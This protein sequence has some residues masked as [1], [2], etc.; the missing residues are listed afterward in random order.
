MTSVFWRRGAK[1]Q[2]WV[3]QTLE[4]AAVNWGISLPHLPAEV[5]ETTPTNSGQRMGYIRRHLPQ[6]SPIRMGSSWAPKLRR[7]DRPL[8]VLDQAFSSTNNS[9]SYLYA[10]MYTHKYAHTHT[11]G[12]LMIFSPVIRVFLCSWLIR[13]SGD[14][15]FTSFSLFTLL[16]TQRYWSCPSLRDSAGWWITLYSFVNNIYICWMKGQM[17]KSGGKTLNFPYFPSYEH[18]TLLRSFP[19]ILFFTSPIGF[20]F[21]KALVNNWEF[22]WWFYKAE[23]FEMALLPNPPSPQQSPSSGGSPCQQATALTSF[24]GV[25][26]SNSSL[27][28]NLHSS[29]HQNK[30]TCRSKD[31]TAV[32]EPPTT[33]S[34]T[35]GANGLSKYFFQTSRVPSLSEVLVN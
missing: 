30:I 23:T 3:V 27:H 21:H 11:Q 28:P 6:P 31:P 26:L 4:A 1:S 34:L 14:V 17:K 15:F 22:S 29:L 19:L 35:P 33:L 25:T 24:H 32:Y 9:S 20:L 7:Q 18:P 13:E 8:Q 12:S 5:Q 10:H 16:L 2:R